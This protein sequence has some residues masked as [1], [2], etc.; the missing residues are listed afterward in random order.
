MRTISNPLFNPYRASL[1]VASLMSLLLAVTAAQAEGFVVKAMTIA[2]KKAVFATVEST[3]AI[4][5]RVRISGTV[6]ELSATEGDLVKEGTVIALVKDPKLDLQIEAIEAQIRAA[7]R[8]IAN[9]KTE[10]ERTQALFQRG[11][12][13]KARLDQINT[14]YDVAKSK[15]EASEAEKAVIVRQLE[16]GAVLA[17]QTGR[18]LDVPITVGSVVMPGEAV[19][20]IAKD[21]Y[22]LRLSLP[23]RHARFLH[24]GDSVALAARGQDCA[25]GCDRTGTIVKVYPQIANGRVLADATVPDLGDYF[26]GERIQV[27]V[28]AGERSA[29]L[30]PED[31]VF[32]RFGVDFVTSRLAD[33]KTADIAVQVGRSHREESGL[34]VEIL[35][36]I[37]AGDILVQ[38]Q[39]GEHGQ[40]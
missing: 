38:P 31:L 39:G 25:K 3:D 32:T 9:L 14:Q 18:V 33:E 26:V 5:A 10:L 21:H 36:G 35:S 23:E 17:P 22:I 6:T 30:V 7:E 20:T 11:S 24:K 27:R 34:M 29:L 13:T 2:D 1:H 16:E 28:S 4:A 19:A 15:L 37:E 40:K 8:E 12:T